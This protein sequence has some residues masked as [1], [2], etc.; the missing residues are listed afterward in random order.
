MKFTE[1]YP[2][3]PI[4]ALS[5][6]QPFASLMLHGKVETRV[7]DS[8]YRGWVL[9]CASKQ[10]YSIPQV[11]DISGLVQAGRAWTTIGGKEIPWRNTKGYMFNLDDMPTGKAIAVGKLVSSRKLNNMAF[12][13]S[14]GDTTTYDEIVENKT[15]VAY[16][17]EL[18]GHTYIDVQPIVPFEWSGVLG[19]KTLNE[20]EKYKIILL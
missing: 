13:K 18:W 10:P 7:W 16:D 14:I 8:K 3:E 4:R 20:E 17:P 5:W 9:I 15:F 12:I 19:W 6:R 11:E 2:D 1:K